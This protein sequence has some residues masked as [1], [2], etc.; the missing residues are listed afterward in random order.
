MGLWL[1]VL[2]P[3]PR[4]PEMLHGLEKCA[5]ILSLSV[6]SWGDFQGCSDP[7]AADGPWLQESFRPRV[8]HFNIAKFSPKK[9]LFPSV[10]RAVTSP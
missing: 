10:G 2:Q 9:L 5:A 3:V 6:N 4:N 1:E 7:A 8:S